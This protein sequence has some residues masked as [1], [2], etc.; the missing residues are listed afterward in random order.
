MILVQAKRP[1]YVPANP[2]NPKFSTMRL[3]QTG[4]V[5]LV[6]QDHGLPEG[7][8]EVVRVKKRKKED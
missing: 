3:V 8:F 2:H 4:L 5:A 6:P 7:S 1:I